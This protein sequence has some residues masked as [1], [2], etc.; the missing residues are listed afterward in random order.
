[1][2][3]AGVTGLLLL[4][5]LCRA[6]VPDVVIKLDSRL[7]YRSQVDG[8]TTL[9]YYDSLGRA[10]IISLGFNLEPGFKAYI[11]QR[12]QRIPHDGDP[13]QLEEYFI[14][15]PG[16]WRVGKQFVPFGNGAL[17]RE[18]AVGARGDFELPLDGVT[19]AIALV[20]SGVGRQ[21]GLAGRV[22]GRFGGRY[23]LSFAVGD[24]WGISASSLALVR[25][26]ERSPGLGH[27]YARMFGVD[28]SQPFGPFFLRA[29]WVYLASG[30]RTVDRDNHVLDVSLTIDPSSNRSYTLGYTKSHDPTDEFYRLQG[31]LKTTKNVYFEPM[32]R[33]RNGDVYDFQVALRVKF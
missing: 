9:R 33:Y 22:T 25:P 21:R 23:G 2:K 30:A 3:L 13:D 28:Y 7:S 4:A 27:G 11:S 16:L 6:Q 12:F 15:D 8:S 32:I 29:E 26:V 1:M 31:S 5:G 18:S 17:I 19:A 20:D 24:H 10:S 14:E